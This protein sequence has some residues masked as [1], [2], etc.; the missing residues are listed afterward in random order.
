MLIL[1]L[2]KILNV[3][4]CKR[5]PMSQTLRLQAVLNAPH[6]GCKCKKPFVCERQPIRTQTDMVQTEDNLKGAAPWSRV[7][8]RIKTGRLK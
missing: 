7:S 4:V 2:A 3:N 8:P 6:D 1:N 5:N